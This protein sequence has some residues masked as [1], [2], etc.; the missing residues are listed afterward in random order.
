MSY[1]YIHENK[2]WI[3]KNIIEYLSSILSIWLKKIIFYMTLIKRQTKEE[4]KSLKL[5]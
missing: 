3:Y 2:S 4:N 5:N 1:L